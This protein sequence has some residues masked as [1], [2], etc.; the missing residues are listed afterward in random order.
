MALQD[1]HPLP[2]LAEKIS[3]NYDIALEVASSSLVHI[4]HWVLNTSL[5]ILFFYIILI[6]FF[7]VSHIVFVPIYIF[8][9]IF[10]L[11][12]CKCLNLWNSQGENLFLAARFKLNLPDKRI[13]VWL[14]EVISRTCKEFHFTSA[15]ILL[16]VLSDDSYLFP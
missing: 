13:Q 11:L 6:E 15:L 9:A 16:K 5:V 10:L 2:Y 14:Q 7:S 8:K 3:K 1:P 4:S 12:N